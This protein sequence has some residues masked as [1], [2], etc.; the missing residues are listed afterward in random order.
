[1]IFSNPRIKFKL[2]T[3]TKVTPLNVKKRKT[4]PP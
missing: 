2:K 3:K 4:L 1:L